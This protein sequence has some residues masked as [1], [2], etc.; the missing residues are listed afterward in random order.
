VTGRGDVNVF[1]AISKY[2]VPLADVE[3]ALPEHARWVAEG[4][5]NGTFLVS[6]RQSPPVGGAMVFVARDHRSAQELVRSD[7]FVHR[8]IAE[9]ELTEFV[10][11]ADERRSPEFA[12]FLG[13][14]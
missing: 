12:I 8:G 7:P 3:A 2:V 10:P 6:G 14:Q 5:G 13:R 11:S 9:Y 1:I 4:Y